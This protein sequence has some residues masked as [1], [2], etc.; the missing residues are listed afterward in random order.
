M[1]AKSE[2]IFDED[3]LF[4]QNP[5]NYFQEFMRAVLNCLGFNSEPPNSP[6]NVDDDGDGIS[7]G[8]IPADPP[9]SAADPPAD[10]PVAVELRVAPPR[11]PPRPPISGGR[12][13]QTN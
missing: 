6:S 12:D 10:P 2:K 5:C 8:Q 4:V 7:S 3:Q 11:A 13:P 1:E 9:S